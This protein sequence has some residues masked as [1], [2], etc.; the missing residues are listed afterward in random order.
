VGGGGERGLKVSEGLHSGS[1]LG[2]RHL[3]ANLVVG[4]E[5]D[6]LRPLLGEQLV[7]P[8]LCRGPL[9]S[10]LCR[11]RLA[12]AQSIALRLLEVVVLTVPLRMGSNAVLDGDED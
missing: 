6:A 7:L 4:V 11:C 10:P 1:S 9:K 3:H 8:L 5:I 12:T 2:R